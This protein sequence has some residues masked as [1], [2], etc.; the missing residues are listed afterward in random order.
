MINTLRAG[1]NRVQIGGFSVPYYPRMGQFDIRYCYCM[2]VVLLGR[3]EKH[4]DS[5]LYWQSYKLFRVT[6]GPGTIFSDYEF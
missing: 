3:N 1:V 6:P 2:V 4:F 5:Q